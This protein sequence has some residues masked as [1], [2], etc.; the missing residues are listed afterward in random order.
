MKIPGKIKYACVMTWLE[1]LDPTL[2]TILQHSWIHV[3]IDDGVGNKFV[4]GTY[5]VSRK[6]WGQYF[7]TYRNTVEASAT[8]SGN[9]KSDRLYTWNK[10]LRIWWWIKYVWERGMDV[11]GK[12]MVKQKRDSIERENMLS[13]GKM[14]FVSPWSMDCVCPHSSW[15]NGG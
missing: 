13:K 11:W 3:C 4:M 2:E 15:L 1:H 14:N 8:L 7:R 10:N 9:I 5:F 12:Q 6:L